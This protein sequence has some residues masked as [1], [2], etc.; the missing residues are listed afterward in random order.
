[1]LQDDKHFK[2]VL[3]GVKESREA[4]K[5]T[6]AKVEKHLEQ[7]QQLQQQQQ[8]NNSSAANCDEAPPQPPKRAGKWHEQTC[9]ILLQIEVDIQVHTQVHIQVETLNFASYS[10]TYS[11]FLSRTIQAAGVAGTGTG[12]P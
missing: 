5:G 12:S 3:D 9:F 1:M 6:A 2:C 7:Q 4:I 10:G 11:D 8:Q